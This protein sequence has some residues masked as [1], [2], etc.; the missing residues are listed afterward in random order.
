M[1]EAAALGDVL[2]G[3]LGRRLE[4]LLGAQHLMIEDVGRRGIAREG[5]EL[6]VQLAGAHA[7]LLGQRVDLDAPPIAE[8]VLDEVVRP[9]EEALLGL[10]E[11][12]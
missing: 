7:E 8:G 2:D 4:Q 6:A 1:L 12:D 9:I 10:G 11:L 5:Y 3:E